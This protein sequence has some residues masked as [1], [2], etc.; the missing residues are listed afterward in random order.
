MFVDTR[1]ARL[2]SSSA[3]SNCS[4]FRISVILICVLGAVGF[5]VSTQYGIKFLVDSLSQGTPGRTNP[6][7]ALALLAGF[8]AADNLLWRVAGWIAAST[9]VRVTGDMRREIFNI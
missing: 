2:L 5:S 9:F 1:G 6:W 3:T 7:R 4:R 8:I